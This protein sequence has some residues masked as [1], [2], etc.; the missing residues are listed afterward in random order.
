MTVEGGADA[1]WEDERGRG[2][3][4]GTVR[5]G[6]GVSVRVTGWTGRG[7]RSVSADEVVRV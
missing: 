6:G 7:V 3:G 5:D 1:A 2:R 4:G